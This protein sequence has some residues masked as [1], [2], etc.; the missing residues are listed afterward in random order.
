[1]ILLQRF[2]QLCLVKTSP[3]DIPASGWL[4]KATLM[5]YFLIS[6][7]VSSIDYSWLLSAVASFTDMVYMMLACWLLLWSRG[8]GARYMQTVTAMAGAGALLNLVALPVVYAY[9]LFADNGQLTSLILLL[10]MVILFWSLLVVAH[11]FRHALSIK[12]GTAVFVTLAYAFIS[13]IVVGLT[14]SGA[15]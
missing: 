4:M 14:I 11:I 7:C 8:M 12:A 5:A 2:V 3:A 10:L 9:R 13:F 6:T 1:M 15:V